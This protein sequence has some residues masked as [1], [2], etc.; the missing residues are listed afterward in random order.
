MSG[1]LLPGCSNASAPVARGDVIYC[2]LWDKP[3]PLQ[4]EIGSSS[5]LTITAGTIEI[6]ENLVI[7]TEPNGVKHVAPPDWYSEVSFK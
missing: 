6:Y 1:L 5:F 7:V 4:G 2:K 3:R